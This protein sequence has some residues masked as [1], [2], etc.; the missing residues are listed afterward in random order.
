MHM[1]P[2]MLITFL[3]M[4]LALQGTLLAQPSGGPYGPVQLTYEVPADA[5]L[6]YYVAPDGDPAAAGDLADNPT[7]IESAIEK[8]TTGDAIIMRGGVYRTGNLRLNQGIT[9]QPYKNERPIVKGTK[10]PEAW[11]PARGGLWRTRWETLFPMAPAG[12]WNRERE[13]MRTPLYKF[14]NDMVF[15]D[16]RMLEPKGW[17]GEIDG[18]SY[19]VDYEAGYLYIGVD[20]AGR[21]IEVT[22]FDNALTR[23]LEVTHGKASDG[24]GV[25]V[26]GITFTQYAYRAIEIHGDNPEGVSTEERHGGAVVRSTFEHCT[27]SFCSRVAGYFRGDHLTIRHCLVSDT[28]TEGIYV[29]SSDDVLLEKNIVTRTNIENI[30][31][32]YASAIKIFNQCHRVICRDNLVIDNPN[33]SGVWYDVGEVNG[34]FI[35]NWVQATDNGFFFEISKG[36][37]CAG[38]VFVDCPTAIHILNSRD[39]EIYN[40][41][42]VNSGVRIARTERSAVGDHF[43]WHPSTGPD[44]DE[45]DGHILAG[46]LFAANDHFHTPR[47]QIAQPQAL[48]GRLTRPQVLRMDHNV[49]VCSLP[50]GDHSTIVWSPHAGDDVSVEFDSPE[51]LHAKYPEYAANSVSFFDYHGP[52]FRSDAL[53]RYELVPGFPR[54]FVEP[55]IP[56]ELLDQLCWPVNRKLKPGAYQ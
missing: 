35:N 47:V 34:V 3:V 31:G 13:L 21:Q 18:D 39:V 48:F 7:T 43:G 14:H 19:W 25:T 28:G 53:S 52:L 22:A 37:V 12:W 38:N 1:I 36:A 24:L 17:A 20:P 26:R 33:A 44:V 55:Q 15:V 23:T 29:L 6:V 4:G 54:E 40:N 50:K 32:Y 11:E 49:F 30:T 5:K 10:V 16:G 42:L 9:I 45:R 41:T 2:R 27:F 46:N 8:V 56:G 51:E